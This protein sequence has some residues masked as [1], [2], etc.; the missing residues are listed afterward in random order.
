MK[1]L[2]KENLLALCY[3][4]LSYLFR[5]KNVQEKIK[6]IYLFGSVAR[7]D[8]DKESDIDIFIDAE[9]RNEEFIK[10]A[11]SRALK[12]MYAIEGKKWEL[13]GILNPFAIKIGDL[14]EWDLKESIMREGIVFF[15]QSSATR[16]QKYLLFSFAV[17]KEPKKRIRVIRRLF[18]R[19]EKEYKEHGV[20]QKHN[21]KIISSRVFL[22]PAS[23]LKETTQFF[24]EEKVQYEFQE[25]WK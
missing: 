21:G 10:K 16:M 17:I 14:E 1:R 11:S 19:M 6:I 2:N 24:A 15:G 5:E 4:Y 13:K 18:G 7:G 20:V 12:K 9:K 23:A 22:V 25:I 8:F 3:V